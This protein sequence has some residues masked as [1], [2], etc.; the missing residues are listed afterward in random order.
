MDGGRTNERVPR[1]LR[2][3]ERGLVSFAARLLDDVGAA[4]D[5]V[6][7]TF[8]ELCR[9][10]TDVPEASLRQWLF[11]VCRR[12]ALDVRRKER[13]MRVGTPPEAAAKEEARFHEHAERA[14]EIARAVAALPET[15]QEVVRLKFEHGLSYAEIAAV[16]GKTVAGVGSLLHV[17]IRTLRARL[18]AG[19]HGGRA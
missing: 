19:L 16:T 11:L 13:R 3:H 12:K 14:G 15:Q 18:G 4:R 6:Q 17:A 10:R 8:L 1:A 9:L 7:E 5:C 2:E